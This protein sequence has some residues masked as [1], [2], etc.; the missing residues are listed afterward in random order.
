MLLYQQINIPQWT[1]IKEKFSYLQ[2]VRTGNEWIYLLDSN[3]ISELAKLLP[4]YSER[5]IKSVLAFGQGPH[6]AQQI[7][8]DGYSASRTRASNTALNIPI[9]SYG[10]MT[11]YSG[12]YSIKETASA[13]KVKY[14]KISWRGDSEPFIKDVVVID[15]PTIVRIDVPHSVI[16]LCNDSR[17]IISIRYSPDILLG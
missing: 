8:I 16:N 5:K 12:D 15:S 6:V 14:L 13:S 17:I 7:H 11:W 10:R 9:K 4:V 3:E 1:A 2:T